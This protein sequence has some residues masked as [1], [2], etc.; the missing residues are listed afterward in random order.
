MR[1]IILTQYYPPE[2]GAPQNRLHSLARNL[3]SAG[4]TVEVQTAMPNYPKMQVFEGY[5][6]RFFQAEEIDGI[7]VRRS[8]I[9]VTKSKA[10]IA[11]LLNYFSFVITSLIVGVRAKRADYILCES[12]PLFLGISAWLIAKVR[13]AQLIFNVSD[14]WPESAE[15]LGIIGDGLPLRAAYR[16]EGWL[17]RQS[18][19]VT[20]QTQGIVADIVRRFSDVPAIWLPNGI[21]DDVVASVER[22]SSWRSQYGLEGKKV[23]MYAGVLGHAQ[24]LEVIVMAAKRLRGNKQIAFVIVG[25][26]PLTEE[27]QELNTTHKAGVIFIPNTPKQIVLGMIADVYSYIVPLKKLDLFKGAIPSKLF[28]PLSFGVPILLGVEGEAKSLFID[29][30]R[31]GLAFEPEDDK[32]LAHTVVRLVEDPKERDQMGRNG[33]EY[34]GSNFNRSVIAKRLIDELDN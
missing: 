32:D 29:D 16:L 20:G 21:D 7:E 24:G 2:T 26:G 10:M 15:K 28:D 27:L 6:R 1:I 19:L 12:P 13:K 5:R 17:Y 34:V 18:C 3:E 11:R 4:H 14:L 31:A 25:D 22:D 9:Y 33:L 30:A 23:F 8:W